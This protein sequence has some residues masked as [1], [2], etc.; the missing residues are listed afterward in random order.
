MAEITAEDME[1]ED[2]GGEV[3][4]DTA[5]DTGIKENTMDQEDTVDTAEDMGIP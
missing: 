4:A 5:K 2:M 1:E 3:M